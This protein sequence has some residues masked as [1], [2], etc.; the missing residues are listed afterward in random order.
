MLYCIYRVD[1]EQ[2]QVEVDEFTQSSGN[3]NSDLKQISDSLQNLT[4]IPF[5][6]QAKQHQTDKL[7]V[8]IARP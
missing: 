6:K 3:L 4:E 7:Q 5:F 8:N 1:H 2:W